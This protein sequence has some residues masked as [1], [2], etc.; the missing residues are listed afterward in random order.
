[1]KIF[2]ISCAILGGIFFLMQSDCPVR[3]GSKLDGIAYNQSMQVALMRDH[4]E[5]DNR[6][7]GSGYKD[8]VD[9]ATDDA[10]VNYH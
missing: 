7:P 5:P 10:P 2:L 8:G 4:C 3:I 9:S 6:G 1:M